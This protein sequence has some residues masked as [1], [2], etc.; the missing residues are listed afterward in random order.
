[1]SSEG[2]KKTNNKN[3]KDTSEKNSQLKN[4]NFHLFQN[5]AT[6]AD[7]FSK[8]KI[9][10]AVRTRLDFLRV[11]S[12]QT[13]NPREEENTTINIRNTPCWTNTDKNYIIKKR[14]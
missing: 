11:F 2:K 12:K 6:K 8:D 10:K 13:T 14:I 4:D 7:R 1:M 3:R 9:I 5:I